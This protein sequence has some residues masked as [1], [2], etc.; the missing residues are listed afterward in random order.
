MISRLFGRDAGE[1][2]RAL[3]ATVDLGDLAEASGFVVEGEIV[4]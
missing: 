2:A 3:P 4:G 1:S